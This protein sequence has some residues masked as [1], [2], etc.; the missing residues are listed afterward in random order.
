MCSSDLETRC[1][2]PDPVP[3]FLLPPDFKVA[4]PGSEGA[5]RW[6]GVWKGKSP[7]TGRELLIVVERVEGDIATVVYAIDAGPSRDLTMS[8]S[9]YNGGRL[10]GDVIVIDRGSGRSFELT[11]AADARS[12]AFAIKQSEGGY[13]ANMV[14]VPEFKP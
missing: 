12:L 10:K 2:P 11:L 4:A 9:R 3:T 1:P 7:L 5:Q 13:T 8:Y 6:L 14:R